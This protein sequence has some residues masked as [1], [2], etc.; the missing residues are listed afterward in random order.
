MITLSSYLIVSFI[1]FLSGVL[2]MLARKNIIAIL[3]GIELILNASALNFVAYSKFLAG[4]MDGQIF[5]LFI[6]VVAAAEA[7]VGLAIV[8]RFYQ[9]NESIHID[10]A[11]QLQG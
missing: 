6:I 1:L 3:L 8:I 11:A 5:S 4:N 2:V 9:I 10:D 7:A